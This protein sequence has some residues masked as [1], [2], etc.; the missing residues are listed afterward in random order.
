MLL[1]DD[2]FALLPILIQLPDPDG[3]ERGVDDRRPFVIGAH[4]AGSAVG[5]D[6]VGGAQGGDGG[7]NDRADLRRGRRVGGREGHGSRGERAGQRSLARRGAGAGGSRVGDCAGIRRGGGDGGFLKE[8]QHH[9]GEGTGQ[10]CA[11]QQA[12]QESLDGEAAGPPR[13]RLH[14]FIISKEW[15]GG[16]AGWVGD[17]WGRVPNSPLP[18][19]PKNLLHYVISTSAFQRNALRRSVARRYLARE[20]D[21]EGFLGSPA[22][23]ARNDMQDVGEGLGRVGA[24]REPALTTTS[25]TARPGKPRRRTARQRPARCSPPA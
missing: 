5:G 21:G 10:Q 4:L 20:Y 2:Q 17:W 25:R 14:A 9:V 24:V 12:Q 19:T 15:A 3:I 11:G 13:G 23:R 16:M 7:I 6:Q 18:A 1:V 8:G 22:G